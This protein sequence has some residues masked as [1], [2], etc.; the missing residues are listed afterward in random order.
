MS[1]M[2]SFLTKHAQSFVFGFASHSEFSAHAL[3]L[4]S[5]QREGSSHS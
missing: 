1:E 4:A 3:Y 2:V 5:L